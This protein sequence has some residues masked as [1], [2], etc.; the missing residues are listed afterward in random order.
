MRRLHDWRQLQA[1]AA[2]CRQAQHAGG[3]H[4]HWTADG[5]ASVVTATAT[6]L[7]VRLLRSL[8]NLRRP[9]RPHPARRMTASTAPTSTVSPASGTRISAHDT[10][11]AAP[12][13]STAALSVSTSSKMSFF[14]TVVA[15]LSCARR[16]PCLRRQFL[17]VAAS[18]RS[19]Q[20]PS[21]DELLDGRRQSARRWAA[22]HPR[23]RPPTATGCA[24]S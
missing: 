8:R 23:V 3:A 4:E 11:N 12:G 17:R 22:R 1:L 19:L 14:S 24:A 15:D 21:V 13:T 20:H 5:A 16:R 18:V 9:L 7:T 6:S 10:G 2:R